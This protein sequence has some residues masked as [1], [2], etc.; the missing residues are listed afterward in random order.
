MLFQRLTWRILRREGGGRIEPRVIF[1]ECAD[2]RHL[3]VRGLDHGRP[4]SALFNSYKFSMSLFYFRPLKS[5][6]QMLMFAVL[7]KANENPEV[8][9]SPYE[10]LGV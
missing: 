3:E 5:Y 9:G 10:T 6:Q 8:L 2:G 4:V 7:F 1:V